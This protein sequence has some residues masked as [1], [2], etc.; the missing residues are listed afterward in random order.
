MS[1]ARPVMRDMHR[2]FSKM[3]M[4]LGIG[5][6]AVVGAAWWFGHASPKRHQVQDFYKNYDAD[7]SFDKMVKAGL[8][9]S[10]NPDGSINA[11]KY[12]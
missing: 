3:T 5:G 1:V 6:G 10:V 8:F 12:T 4:I 11:E 7:K 2:N 9:Q